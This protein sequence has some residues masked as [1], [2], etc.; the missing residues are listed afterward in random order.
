MMLNWLEL[1]FAIN[2]VGFYDE[3]LFY[4]ETGLLVLVD[5]C[6]NCHTNKRTFADLTESDDLTLS[7]ITVEPIDNP[8]L[9]FAQAQNYPNAKRR[10]QTSA[11]D[12]FE[13]LENA[14]EQGNIDLALQLINQRKHFLEQQ[15]SRGETPLLMAARLNRERLVLAILKDQLNLSVQVDRQGNNILHLLA[16]ISENRAEKTIE[17]IFTLLEGP[18]KDRLILQLNQSQEKPVDIARNRGHQEYIEFFNHPATFLN[19]N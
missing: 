10:M 11:V 9:D 12:Q 2:Q 17:A 4:F 16:N 18:L 7:D 5:T 3:F 6:L 15:N 1:I 19:F 14:I 8:E 13:V